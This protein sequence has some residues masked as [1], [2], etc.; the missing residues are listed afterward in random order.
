[1]TAP[2]KK[3]DTGKGKVVNNHLIRKANDPIPIP[4]PIQNIKRN[5][6]FFLMSLKKLLMEL[7]NR[8]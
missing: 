1:M 8:S 3:K 6:R 7:I 2:K 4:D 5:V